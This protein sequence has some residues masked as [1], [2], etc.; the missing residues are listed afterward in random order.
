[1]GVEYVADN[2]FQVIANAGYSQLWGGRNYH[3][4]PGSVPSEKGEK[5][6]KAA[7]G[8]GIMLSV[9]LGKAF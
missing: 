4:A 6:L 8:S 5:A 9:S 3:F 1:M 7:F 2:G